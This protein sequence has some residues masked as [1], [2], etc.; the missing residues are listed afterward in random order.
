MELKDFKQISRNHHT[1]PFF[2]GKFM[3]SGGE[4]RPGMESCLNVGW[5]CALTEMQANILAITKT[6]H[7]N[8]QA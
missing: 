8:A 1:R 3:D 7:R 6:S 5:R 2:H 4:V